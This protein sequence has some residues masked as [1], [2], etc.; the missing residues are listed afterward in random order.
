MYVSPQATP[1][2]TPFGCGDNEGGGGTSPRP[3]EL[4]AS[5]RRSTVAFPIGGPNFPRT[6]RDLGPPGT[7]MGGGSRSET[8]EELAEREN[9]VGC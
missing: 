3:T 2:N 8:D 4:G 6:S 5:E 7:P 1:H 9:E